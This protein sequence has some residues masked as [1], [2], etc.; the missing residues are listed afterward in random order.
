VIAPTAVE[1]V[2]ADSLRLTVSVLDENDELITG[3]SVGFASS[4][5]SRVAVSNVG[6]VRSV[7]AFGSAVV[8][9]S[10]GTGGNR[11][12]AE[13]PVTVLAVTEE[14]EVSPNPVQVPQASS[15]QVSVVARD[16]FGEEIPDAP[17]TFTSLNPTLFAVSATGLLQ[18]GSGSG[19]GTLRVTSGAVEVLIPVAVAVVPTSIGL[20]P[21][22][23][24]LS[25]G[26]VGSVSGVVRD[27][28]GSPISGLVV[29][30]TS[31]N[32]DVLRVSPDGSYETQ[33]LVGSGTIT[34]SYGALSASIPFNVTL[35]GMV[36]GRAPLP[37]QV[38]GVAVAST[39]AVYAAAIGIGIGYGTLP[40]FQM[41]YVQTPGNSY[42][43]AVD[44]SGTGIYATGVF[45]EYV[46]TR[47]DPVTHAPMASS[48]P[49]LGLVFSLIVASDGSRVFA[50]IDGGYVVA[51][52]PTTL[53]V[54][55]QQQPLDWYTNHL[56][57]HP[58]QNRLYASSPGDHD[59]VELDGTTL[60]TLRT[61]TL[62]GDWQGI[63]V[64]PDGASLYAVGEGTPLQVWDLATGTA[65]PSFASG[66][67]GFGLGISPDGTALWITR[68][69]GG[70]ISRIDLPTGALHTTYMV[71]GSPRRISVHPD[72]SMVAFANE[73]G[74][75]DFIAP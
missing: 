26:E 23:L 35:P 42:A 22:A 66:S 33:G 56:A 65:G 31:S 72:G 28:G 5:A 36:T 9:V 32:P 44:P 8:T 17:L 11:I 64:S 71:G 14:L 19:G 13:V 38:Y 47:L 50:G 3:I 62:P 53:A 54:L 37:G 45:S 1:I 29:T 61:F 60:A 4:D 10:A 75:V 58:T 21:P 74:W 69:L 57:V 70:N 63:A 24:E 49:L 20:F 67:G 43:V 16:P 68:P 41:S 52:D 59:I 34:A 15:V 46:V 30:Y 2:Q 18:A 55:D 6:M 39:G 40:A 7:G 48:P 25:V 51:L 12:E 73:G 27:A